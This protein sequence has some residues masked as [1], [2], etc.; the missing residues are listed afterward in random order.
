M[1]T[2]GAAAAQG[3]PGSSCPLLPT[4]LSPEGPELPRRCRSRIRAL[5]PRLLGTL[6]CSSR[7]CVPCWA[8]FRIR[9]DPTPSTTPRQTGSPSS[10]NNNTSVPLLSLLRG[11]GAPGMAHPTFQGSCSSWV[12]RLSPLG[13]QFQV[14][15]LPFRP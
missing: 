8:P 2:E 7:V 4:L 1:N 15:Q 9:F 5:H 12:N 10:E 3:K 14:C 11:P 13:L 6:S